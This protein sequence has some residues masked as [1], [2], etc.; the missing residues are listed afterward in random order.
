MEFGG[1]TL[2][3]VVGRRWLVDESWKM[4]VGSWKLKFGFVKT[5]KPKW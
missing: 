3:V 2:E 1:G 4:E 5:G